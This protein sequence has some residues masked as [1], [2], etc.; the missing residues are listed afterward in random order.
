M[1]PLSKQIDIIIYQAK[2]FDPLKNFLKETALAVSQN[3]IKAL[4]TDMDILN[5]R[6]SKTKVIN[7]NGNLL[8][9][10]FTD[11]HTHFL[12]F[13]KRREEIDLQSC[14]SLNSALKILQEKVNRTPEGEWITGGGWNVNLW[15]DDD[16]PTRHQLDQIS[17]KHFIALDSKDY[18]SSW[19]NTQALQFFGIPIE[20]L[21]INARSLAIDRVSGEFSGVLE[22]DLHFAAKEMIP[23]LNFNRLQD[24]LRK[25]ISEFHRFGYSSI[26][27][28]ETPSE[29]EIIREGLEKDELG[30]RLYWYMPIK[31]LEFA[32]EVMESQRKKDLN[33][34]VGTKIFVD[35]TFG[36]RTAELLENYNGLNH[37]G[38]EI[39]DEKN[40]THLVHR[41]VEAKLPC[42]IHAIGD[43]AVR[44]TL[45]VLK[46]FKYQSRESGL[47]HRIE[48]VQLIH[49][50]DLKLFKELNIAVSVQPKHLAEDLLII[51]KYFGER[52]KYCYPYNSLVK[53]GA[54]LLFGSDIPI[55]LYNPWEAIYSALERKAN[56]DS[57]QPSFNPKEKLD[58]QTCITAY[59]VNPAEVVGELDR[60]G[61]IE[62]GK[63][64]DLFVTNQNI[65]EVPV[66]N[67]KKTHSLL[68]LVNGKIVH[69][70]IE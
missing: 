38:G 16:Y 32:K 35:G 10:A 8:L 5:L 70:E 9:P 17:T 46:K 2:I 12:S 61:R 66:E 20:T 29:F 56:L 58:L 43:K 27:T 11:S 50:D 62:A 18:H 4:G 57:N 13:V 33:K 15:P 52:G 63:V 42:A 69:Q 3:Y 21:P 26:H 25:T 22:E 54:K 45:R 28:M 14:T 55:A 40:L 47:Y 19:V 41:T 59:T 30:I 49:P 36:S 44:K 51:R 31:H 64:A 53:N 23:E 65:F 48:H 6:Q 1:S 67:L 7:L 34:L 37:A 60:L 24:S 68:T 39:L